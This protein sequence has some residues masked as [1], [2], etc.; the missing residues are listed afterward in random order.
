M[1]FTS[2]SEML[3]I[4]RLKGALGSDHDCVKKS[5]FIL[6][7]IFICMKNMYNMYN[8][9]HIYTIFFLNCIKV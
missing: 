4:S 1:S 8:K 2:L 6:F 7:I 9:I 3:S 5:F